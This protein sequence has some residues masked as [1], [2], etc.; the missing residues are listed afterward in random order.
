MFQDTQVAP[1]DAEDPNDPWAE[2]RITNPGELAAHL[3]QLRD[4]QQPIF[5]HGSNNASL[6]VTLWEV[7]PS[8][9]V[10]TLSLDA[11]QPALNAVVSARKA[12]A[13]SYQDSVKFQF[14]MEEL[15]LVQGM[16]VQS[17]MA[18][19]PRYLYRLQ[20][21]STYRVRVP[22]RGGPVLRFRHPARPEQIV[23]CRMLDMSL[24][25][26]GALVTEGQDGLK[27]GLVIG[28]SRIDLNPSARFVT[29]IEVRRMA[30]ATNERDEVIGVR[31]GCAW[32][33]LDPA[34]ERQLQLYVEEQQKRH[35]A[36]GR[37]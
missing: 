23:T 18:Q 21:R 27:E 30:P 2:Y 26:C 24:G 15:R 31:L 1:I 37:R 9:Q 32:T 13:V 35:R 36:L 34:Q 14:P 11:G 29:G 20:Q 16:Q 17:L 33:K 22:D 4:S 7:D 5:L 28:Q 25:G 6:R 10:V 19:M 8:R 3:R 12:M